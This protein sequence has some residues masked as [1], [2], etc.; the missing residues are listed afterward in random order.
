M[1]IFCIREGQSSLS[2]T[3][4]AKI[5]LIKKSRSKQS[6]VASIILLQVV[7][8]GVG[9]NLEPKP[10]RDLAARGAHLVGVKSWEAR[11][12]G[13]MVAYGE[14]LKNASGRRCEME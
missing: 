12:E 14:S 10:K 11:L 5:T 9:M 7:K 3:S 1:I 4:T 13:I 2:G 8:F 6:A